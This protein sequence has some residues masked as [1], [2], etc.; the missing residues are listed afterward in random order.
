MIFYTSPTN[1]NNVESVYKHR[2]PLDLTQQPA[3]GSPWQVTIDNA[4]GVPV[5][6]TISCP[7]TTLDNF[8]FG[9]KKHTH[10]HTNFLDTRAPGLGNGV[11]TGWPHSWAWPWEGTLLRP[12]G[13]RLQTHRQAPGHP[14]G[15]LL[16][17]AAGN[18]TDGGDVLRVVVSTGWHSH[19]RNTR[20]P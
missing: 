12:C 11:S 2:A 1:E 5:S 16:R 8:Y 9:L 7:L 4:A 13:L 10:T 14:Q 20:A 15:Y 6:F 19:C 3:A 18:L 17:K